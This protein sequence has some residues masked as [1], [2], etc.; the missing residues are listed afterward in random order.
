MRVAFFLDGFPYPSETF[1][2]NQIVEV[3]KTG[4]AVDL[5][6]VR[7]IFTTVLHPRVDKYDLL[8][9]CVYVPVIPV[10]RNKRIFRFLLN[11]LPRYIPRP[12]IFFKCISARDY[13]EQIRNLSIFFYA[14]PFFRKPQYDIIHCHFGPIGNLAVLIKQLGL[15]SGKIVTTFH[16][17][18]LNKES[19]RG[20]KD[21][22]KRLFDCGSAFTVNSSFLKQKAVS[23]GCPPDKIHL[24][25]V[26]VDLEFFSPHQQGR[27]NKKI[28]ILTVANLVEVKGIEYSI[29]AVA[30]L[31][32]NVEYNIIG[33]GPLEESLSDLIRSLNAE[34]LIKLLGPKNQEEVKAAYSTSD[35]FMLTSIKAGD[36]SEEAQGL[37]IQEAQAMGLPVIVTDVGGI[38]EGLINEKS[39]FIVG[40]KD[41]ASIVSRLKILVGNQALRS[42]M[43]EKGRGFVTQKYN[44]KNLNQDLI[45]LYAEV[46]YRNGLLEPKVY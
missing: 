27:T 22:Y 12:L 2:V 30:H 43:G 21:F 29:K 16:G 5:Y 4:A 23:L 1:I 3:I 39:G 35:I 34:G 19:I 28:R 8:K 20:T 6:S 32:N 31:R 42:E 26:G 45:K 10:G 33:S 38:P 44:I 46:L 18:D 17:Y 25:P 36:G 15:I 11:I 13:R 9:R 40:Q 7:R 14:V 41:V 37:V 24:L